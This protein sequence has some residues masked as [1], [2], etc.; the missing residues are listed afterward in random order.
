[1]LS[2][3]ISVE[4]GTRITEQLR[5]KGIEQRELDALARLALA[6][7]FYRRGYLSFGL[8]AELAGMERAELMAEMARQKAPVLVLPESELQREFDLLD[9][10]MGK[11]GGS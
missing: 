5:S 4:L 6:C 8:A 9:S 10:M 2:E 3:Q 11:K 1:M 7:E